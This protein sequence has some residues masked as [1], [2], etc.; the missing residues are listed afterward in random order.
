MDSNGTDLTYLNVMNS[1]RLWPLAVLSFVL[2]VSGCATTGGG[3][4]AV[5]QDC[6]PASAAKGECAAG[7]VIEINEDKCIGC[8]T[9]VAVC[10][11]Q[12]RVLELRETGAGGTKSV[13]VHQEA[14]DGRAGCVNNC[15]VGAIRLVED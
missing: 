11:A 7:S 1:K 2:L 8:G 15:P 10:P 6:A 13:V 3:T 5:R 12:P 4:Q 14:C 9:C